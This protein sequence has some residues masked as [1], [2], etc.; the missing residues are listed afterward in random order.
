M[1]KAL[2][3]VQHNMDKPLAK[4]NTENV[5]EHIEDSTKD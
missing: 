3:D 4:T 1:D 5:D 2:K